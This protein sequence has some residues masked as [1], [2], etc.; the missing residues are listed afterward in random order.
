MKLVKDGIKMLKNRKAEWKDLVVYEQLTKSIG[1][2]KLIS[3]HIAAAK[4]L[5]A[6]FSRIT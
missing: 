6:R 1:E 5:I 2:Y 3:P 4:K